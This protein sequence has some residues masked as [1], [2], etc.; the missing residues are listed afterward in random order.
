[1]I[2]FGFNTI[3]SLSAF[4]D[5]TTLG[6]GILSIE[7]L[8]A[9]DSTLG[10]GVLMVSGLLMIDVLIAVYSL[11]DLLISFTLGAVCTSCGGLVAS[12]KVTFLVGVLFVVEMLLRSSMIFVNALI[13]SIPFKSLLPLRACVESSRALMIVSAGVT[14]G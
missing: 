14:V 9:D 8:P 3:F 7:V 5:S 13:C 11:T 6:G 2:L 4:E 12:S 1:L 10:G